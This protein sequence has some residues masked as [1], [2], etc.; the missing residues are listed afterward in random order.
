MDRG[1]MLYRKFSVKRFEQRE[2]G[3]GVGG[4]SAFEHGFDVG[5]ALKDFGKLPA[6]FVKKV[7]KS[8]R[9]KRDYKLGVEWGKK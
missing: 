6:Q 8:T 5:Q 3:L 2:S 9:A 7:F 4:T 1:E